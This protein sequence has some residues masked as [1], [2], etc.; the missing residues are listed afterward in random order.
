MFIFGANR[1]LF[2]MRTLISGLL[3]LISV[4]LFAQN[5]SAYV[6]T[7]V[8]ELPAT[9]VKDQHRSGTCWSF[10]ALSFIESEVLRKGGSE[11]DLSE[12]FVVRKCYE[13]KAD[14]YVRMQGQIN[15]AAGGAFFDAFWVLENYG[16]VP[17]SAYSGLN[18]GE[19]SHVHGELDA[20]TKSFVDVIKENKNRKLSTAWKPAFNGILDAYFGNVPSTFEFIGEQCTPASF[21]KKYVDINVDDYVSVTSYTHHPFYE[22]FILEIPDNWIWEESYNVTIDEL[23]QIC[24][25]AVENGYSVAWGGDVSEKGFSHKNG[26]AIVPEGDMKE[27]SDT[28]RSRWEKMSESDRSKALNTFGKPVPEKKITQEMRQ[29]EFDNFQTTDDHGMHITGMLTDQYGKIYYKVKNSWNTDNK[30]DG[31]LYMSEAYVKLK[32]MNI[33]VHKDGVPKQIRKKLGF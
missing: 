15:F 20:A 23:A 4:V 17:E 10:S 6:F 18:Y 31:N 19:E 7:M 21:A 13:Y 30:Y 11:L 16:M 9:S 25:Y 3:L 29:V 14:K 5:D 8:K 22:K 26:L 28:E 2:T 33:M 1:K 32:T 27:M 12:M 24:R